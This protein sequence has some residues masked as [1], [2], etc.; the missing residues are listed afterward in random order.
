M[1][2]VLDLWLPILLA[3]VFVFVVSSVV[4]MCLPIHKGDYKKLANEADV[5]AAM[6]KAGV[7]SGEFMFPC[8]TSMKDMA[9][10]EML[11]KYKQGPVGFLTLMPAGAPTM[12]K[13]LLQ[14]FLWCVVVG[15]FVAYIGTLSLTRGADATAVFRL[16]TAVA[17]LGYAFSNVT[18][19]IWKGCSWA[20][21]IK[22]VF[23]GVLYALA[24]AAAF[25][26]C[27]PAAA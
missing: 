4:H 3:A 18:A 25:V 21:T 6:R 1:L 27:W 13:N 5:L 14:W 11:E 9:S 16:T 20:I 10:P 15:V 19:S 7:T 26:W 22:F 8:P 17:L 12:G 2:N 24:T 23:D